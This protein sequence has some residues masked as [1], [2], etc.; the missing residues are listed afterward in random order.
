MMGGAEGLAIGT[1]IAVPTIYSANRFFP[2][3][4]ALPVSLKMFSVIF[5]LVPASV[6]QAERAGLAFER[7]TLASRTH[8]GAGRSSLSAACRDTLDRHEQARRAEEQRQVALEGSGLDR[9][10]DWAS[11]HK[12]GIV[13]GG[14]VA[15]MGIAMGVVM[16]DPL[17]SFSQKLVQA[18]MWGAGVDHCPRHRRCAREPRAGEGTAR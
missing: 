4:R 15:G 13:G 3:Y 14:W 1:A 16:R 8:F 6:I 12:F 9:A 17:Q 18:R 2:T 7:A 10:K 5:L 11:K